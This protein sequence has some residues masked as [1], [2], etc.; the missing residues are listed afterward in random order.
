MDKFDETGGVIEHELYMFYIESLHG[1]ASGHSQH[2][3]V[4]NF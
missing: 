3:T 4:A 2:F 1:I